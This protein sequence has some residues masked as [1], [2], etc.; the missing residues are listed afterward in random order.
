VKDSTV[1]DYDVYDKND[2][3]CWWCGKEL[4]FSNCGK[5]GE[6]GARE[7]DHSNPV[8]KGGTD[9]LRNLVLA[10]PVEGGS[11]GRKKRGQICLPELIHYEALLP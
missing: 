10:R 4:A 2:G 11:E 9:Y 5:T 7:I 3:Y 6:K 8:S 1:Y